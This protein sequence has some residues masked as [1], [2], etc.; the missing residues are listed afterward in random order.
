MTHDA[1]W[2]VV[3]EETIDYVLRDLALPSGGLCSAEDADSEGEEG[4]FYLWKPSEISTVL[5]AKTGAVV[6]RWYGATDVGNFGG[7]CI[8]RRL[9]GERLERP[10]EV[11]DARS[12]RAPRLGGGG[13]QA[14]PVPAV[15]ATPPGRRAL[16]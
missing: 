2:L 16:A 10:R 15:R 4:R 7:R 8:L 12:H 1:R 13:S 9:P 11:E 5:G 6:S 14:R 3:V